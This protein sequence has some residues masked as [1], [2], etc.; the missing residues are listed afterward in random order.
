MTKGW[1]QR[2]NFIVPGNDWAY[3]HDEG[4]EKVDFKDIRFINKAKVKA[5]F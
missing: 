5:L 1:E 3:N 2:I 4:R